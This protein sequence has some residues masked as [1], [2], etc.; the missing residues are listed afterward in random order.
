MRKTRLAKGWASRGSALMAVTMATRIVLIRNATIS[1][2]IAPILL[3]DSLLKI[4]I[5]KFLG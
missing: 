2:Q 4:A 3:T 1:T 5:S